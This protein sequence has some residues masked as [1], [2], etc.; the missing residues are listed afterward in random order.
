VNGHLIDGIQ[1][2]AFFGA[3]TV[4]GLLI[5]TILAYLEA[6]A[7][8]A[9][10]VTTTTDAEVTGKRKRFR[11]LSGD[12]L[13]PFVTLLVM[14]AMLLAGLTWIKAGMDNAVQD[15]RD[16]R[17]AQDTS[18]VLRSRTRIYIEAATAEK[19]LWTDLHDFI[20]RVDQA[21]PLLKSIDRYR[22]R[23]ADYLEHL[24][25]NPYPKAGEC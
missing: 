19:R 12:K 16:C 7:D 4:F 13:M 20:A 21:S 24:Q 11:L 10:A 9:R 8:L 6:R 2:I 14:V 18:Q 15:R 17:E 5:A 3:G 25:N 1:A 22:E 23:Q